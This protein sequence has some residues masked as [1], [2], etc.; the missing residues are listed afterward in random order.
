MKKISAFLSLVMLVALIPSACRNNPYTPNTPVYTLSVNGSL[1]Y[2][3]SGTGGADLSAPLTISAGQSITWD[4]SNNG[5]HPL[6]IDNGS[7]TCSVSA[8]TTFPYTHTFSS[9]GDF[10]F[11][12]GNHGTCNGGGAVCTLPCSAMAG[13]VHVQ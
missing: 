6:Y 11:H 13:S 7:G 5:I 2:S 4:T 1:R 8:N 12:C 10:T 3:T 9:T